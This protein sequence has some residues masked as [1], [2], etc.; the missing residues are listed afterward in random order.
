MADNQDNPGIRVPP[1]LVYLLALLLGLLLNR[2]LDVP[3]L[4]H[5]VPRPR[6]AA[7]GEWDSARGMVRSDDA[8][9]RHYAPHRQARMQPRPG[10]SVPLQPQPRLPL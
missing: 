7:C 3:F 6:V 4:P 10:R 2:R 5:G 1:P 8:Q 9:R